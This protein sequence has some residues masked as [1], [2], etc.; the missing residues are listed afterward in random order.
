MNQYEYRGGVHREG[1][2]WRYGGEDKGDKNK[3]TRKEV[4]GCVQAVVGRKNF[5][6][7]FKD[8]QKE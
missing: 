7:Q 2:G 4:V 5:L 6:V 1:K 3:R 8:S